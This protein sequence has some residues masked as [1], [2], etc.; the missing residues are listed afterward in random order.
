MQCRWRW[1]LQQQCHSIPIHDSR[2]KNWKFEFL[3]LFFWPALGRTCSFF[4]VE[5]MKIP[6]MRPAAAVFLLPNCSV[7]SVGVTRRTGHSLKQIFVSCIFFG[8]FENLFF[9]PAGIG[10]CFRVVAL[11]GIRIL[12]QCADGLFSCWSLIGYSWSWKDIF[13]RNWI[14]LPTCLT[15]QT[16]NWQDGIPSARWWPVLNSLQCLKP[17]SQLLPGFFNDEIPPSRVLPCIPTRWPH[18]TIVFH[19][20]R[21]STYSIG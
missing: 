6:P 12:V 16:V 1:R 4:V 10:N 11:Y 18:I 15:C 3:L 9:W 21:K 19:P 2:Q 5:L 8:L 20:L 17:L 13:T 14:V 7:G